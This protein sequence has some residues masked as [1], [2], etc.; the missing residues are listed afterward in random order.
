MS[1]ELLTEEEIQVIKD[2]VL[3]ELKAWFEE[4]RDWGEWGWNTKRDSL[5]AEAICKAQIAK[6]KAMGW[7]SPGQLKAEGWVELAKDQSLPKINSGLFSI[8]FNSGYKAALLDVVN[9]NFRRIQ[10]DG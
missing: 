2:S 8:P 3:D 7:L 6:L 10:K 9:T 5:Y 1:D 4:H